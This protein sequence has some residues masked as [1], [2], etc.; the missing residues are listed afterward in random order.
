MLEK[1]RLF[2]AKFAIDPEVDFGFD[3]NDELDYLLEN[4]IDPDMDT[5][6]PDELDGDFLTDC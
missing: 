1:D 2:L 4:V 5:I 3:G 6:S